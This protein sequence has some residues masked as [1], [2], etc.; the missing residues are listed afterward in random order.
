MSG[1]TIFR[2]VTR[3][4][5]AARGL[6]YALIGYLALRSGRT[7]DP[8]GILDYL[9]SAAGR[10]VVAAMA[11]GFFAYAAWRLLEA[12]VDSEGHGSNWKGLGVRAAGVGSGIIH[13][14]FGGAAVRLVLGAHEGGGDTSKTAA[15]TALHLPG[16]NVI[17]YLVAAFL[18]GV[19]IAQLRK[20]WRL[21][22]LRHFEGRAAAQAWIAWL[23]RLGYVTRG[24]IF[25]IVAWLFLHAAQARSPGAA[26]GIDDAL[27]SLPRLLQIAVAI[28]LLLF[29]LFSLAEARFRRLAAPSRV[30]RMRFSPI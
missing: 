30:S 10:F 17:L 28:G 9:T 2:I 7:E 19:A 5:F 6:M 15:A 20:A 25:M 8:R 18:A 14:G 4:G 16:G 24:I 22:F 29:G 12:W 3:L 11:V 27:A 13:F 26:G 23:G 1:A 21:K